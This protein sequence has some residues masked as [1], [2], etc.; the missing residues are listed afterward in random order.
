[1]YFTLLGLLGLVGLIISLLYAFKNGKSVVEEN[2][3]ERAR[4]TETDALAKLLIGLGK[5]LGGLPFI[6]DKESSLYRAVKRQLSLAG[7]AYGG[8]VEVFLS[9]I[10]AGALL[11]IAGL[12]IGFIGVLPLWF[13][14]VPGL[15]LFLLPISSV[16]RRARERQE[17][18]SRGLP[19]FA[20][21]LQMPLTAGMSVIASLEFT[22]RN[23]KGPVSDE[24]SNVVLLTK[25]RV[26]RE[27]EAFIQAG[28][29]LG[30]PEARSFF[31]ALMQAYLEG[32]HV[33]RT[34]SRQAKALR[35]A[36]YQREREKIKKLPVRLIFVFAL[37]FLIP[38]LVIIG[39]QLVSGFSAL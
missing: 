16:S 3:Y 36:Q 6:H 2:A 14:P 12:L 35:T 22:A 18:I 31:T 23:T 21:L 19:E 37:H 17:E 10:G 7:G 32:S 27:D 1:M 25:S 26:L 8:S 13:A 15:V 29:N 38:I 4:D 20:E 9:A 33:V 11:A 30:T 28:E 34:I 24:A 5:P 39:I